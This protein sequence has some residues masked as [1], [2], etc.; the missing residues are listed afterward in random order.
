MLPPPRSSNRNVI[1]SPM[2]QTISPDDVILSSPGQRSASP[3]KQIYASSPNPV[4][5]TQSELRVLE[6][7]QQRIKQINGQLDETLL[8]LSNLYQPMESSTVG[9]VIQKQRDDYKKVITDSKKAVLNLKQEIKTLKSG[10]KSLRDPTSSRLISSQKAH[11][12]LS[13]KLSEQVK[14]V[15]YKADNVLFLCDVHL[16]LEKEEQYFKKL[17]QSEKPDCQVKVMDD[18]EKLYSQTEKVNTDSI[19]KTVDTCCSRFNSI[20]VEYIQMKKRIENLM[21]NNEVKT[22]LGVLLKHF[23]NKIDAQLNK[24]VMWNE[25]IYKLRYLGSPV[26]AE[27]DS[28]NIESLQNEYAQFMSEIGRNYTNIE[29]FIKYQEGRE[30]LQSACRKKNERLKSFASKQVHEKTA[31][32]IKKFALSLSLIDENL[33]LLDE[34]TTAAAKVKST[35]DYLV[36][37]PE[38][39]LEQGSMRG[40]LKDERDHLAQVARL[41]QSLQLKAGREYDIMKKVGEWYLPQFLTMCEIYDL[42]IKYFNKDGNR[43]GDFQAFST[44][45]NTLVRGVNEEYVKM[46]LNKCLRQWQSNV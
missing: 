34:C 12:E 31:E 19:K 35:V 42:I 16:Q 3:P 20:M 30:G 41:N 27:L 6:Q 18:A 13:D 33:S 21:G 11:Y 7:Y 29:Q 28:L 24:C 46:Q 23:L 8:Y 4:I 39:E 36:S 2:K 32:K 10:I 17:Y 43:K 15:Q 37:M 22:T 38:S 40:H 25:R 9:D 44:N 26:E 5:D 45:F 14:L 1:F